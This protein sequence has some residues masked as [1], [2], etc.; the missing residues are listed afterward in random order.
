MLPVAPNCHYGDEVAR[1]A[2]FTVLSALGLSAQQ[3]RLY[4]RLEPLSGDEL[5]R[6]AERFGISED[7]LAKRLE[8]LVTAGLVATVDGRLRTL[9]VAAAVSSLIGAEAA[10]AATARR[11]LEDLAAAIPY[12]TAATTRPGLD[13]VEGVTPLEGELSTGGNPTQL[14]RDFV[15]DTKGDLMWLRPDAWRMPRESAISRV[16]AAAVA[17]GRRSRAVYPAVALRE[18]PEALRT[19]AEA[20]EEIRVVPELPTRLIVVG[21]THA[22]VPEPMGPSDEPRLLIRQPAIVEGFR[23]LFDEIWNRAEPVYEYEALRGLGRH[24]LLIQQLAA[25]AKDEHIAR[26][27]GLSLRTVRRRIAEMLD[28]F[29]V[30]TR[31]QAGIEASRRGLL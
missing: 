20:G 14:L 5:C 9:P 1:R 19:R 6:I 28:D 8:P 12:L 10:A 11:R 18:A 23:M 29:N 2:G 17:T 27:L 31:F 3:E 22:V 21:N 16:I 13:A 25:G 26:T 4:Q 30:E 24:R 7:A 15:G